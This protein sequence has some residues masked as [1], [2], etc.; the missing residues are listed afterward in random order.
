MVDLDPYF[1]SDQPTRI[2]FVVSGQEALINTDSSLA[3]L[4]KS[5]MER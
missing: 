4:D 1:L 5:E 3:K 2:L